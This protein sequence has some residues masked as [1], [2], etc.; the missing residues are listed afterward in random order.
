MKRII[1]YLKRLVEKNSYSE[2]IEIEQS[3][4]EETLRY[5]NY[6]HTKEMS[7]DEQVKMYR[8]LNKDKLIEMLIECNRILN[9]LTNRRRIHK[10]EKTK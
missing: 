10:V 1:N 3:Y 6:Y 2:G 5:C 9:L 8:T 4:R 7:H